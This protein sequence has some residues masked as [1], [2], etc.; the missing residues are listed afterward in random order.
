MQ[1]FDYTRIDW[2]L[3]PSLLASKANGWQTSSPYMLGFQDKEMS[4]GP[5]LSEWTSPF[6]RKDMFSLPSLF[7]T[8][9]AP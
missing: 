6:A 4:V 1:E 3:D 2:T 8:S 9:P 7:V 5:G